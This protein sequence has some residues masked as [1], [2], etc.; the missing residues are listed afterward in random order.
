MN[1]LECIFPRTDEKDGFQ[2]LTPTT[3]ENGV[4]FHRVRVYD[5]QGDLVKT[6]LIDQ[7][8][9]LFKDTTDIQDTPNSSN[10]LGQ[11]MELNTI[12]KR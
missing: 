6:M 8:G 5:G 2:I 7:M 4:Y 11:L 10:L 3:P 12:N 1:T 9:T